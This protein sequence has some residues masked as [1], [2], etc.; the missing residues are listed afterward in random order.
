MAS[1]NNWTLDS[2]TIR[3]F[4]GVAG[5]QIYRFDGKPGLL[6]GNNGVGKSTAAQC[7][8]WTLYGKF[9]AEVLQNTAFNSFM[10]PVGTSGAKWYGQAT[11]SNG[12]G[13]MIVTR[14][15]TP[16]SFSVEV[17]STTCEGDEAVEQLDR[18]LGLDMSGFVRTVLLQQSRIRGLLLDSPKDR[19][20]ALDRLL[21]MDD[22]ENI[23]TRLKPRDFIKTAEVR[24]ENIRIAQQDH[25]SKEALLL[26]QRDEA[27][28]H[29]REYQ[30]RSKDFNIVGLRNAFTR[31]NEQLATLAAKYEVDLATLPECANVD[32]AE[33]ISEQVVAALSRIRS[34]SNLQRKLTEVDGKISNYRALKSNFEKEH[35]KLTDLCDQRDAWLK[36]KGKPEDIEAR[37]KRLEQDLVAART[38]LKA[39]GELRQLLADARQYLEHSPSDNCPVCEQSIASPAS[40]IADLSARLENTTTDETAAL[41]NRLEELQREI[42]SINSALEN[43]G[44][45]QESLKKAQSA[46]DEVR[47]QVVDALGGTGIPESKVVTR[48]DET[49]LASSKGRDELARGASAIE[50]HLSKVEAEDRRINS[51]L[52]PVIRRR[53]DLAK[54]ED[55]WKQAQDSHTADEEAAAELELVAD[56]FAELRE[57]LLG[58]KNEIATETLAI[59][60]PRAEGLYQTLVRHPVFDRLQITTAPKANKIDY[61]FEVSIDGDAKSARE[62]RLVLSDGQVTATAIGLFFALSDAD[63]HNLDLLYVDDPTQNL[64]SPC[65]E[66]MAKVIADIGKERQVIIST[67]DEDFV[68]FLEA[69]GFFDSAVVHHLERWDGNPVVSTRVAQ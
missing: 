67:Q 47:G 48:L 59:A 32:E 23:L 25:E 31:I 18:L 19:N 54:L 63:T 65:K 17:D 13:K 3:N 56:Q 4:R 50:E 52:I 44:E 6:H 36:A 39:A 9:P 2:L 64:D 45:V 7:L 29:A 49:I 34:D 55:D 11:F 1:E 58:A 5:E 68:S 14:S 27:Q 66:A 15:Q 26:K 42:D 41:E 53:A 35:G 43:L 12:S 28:Q 37:R 57:A 60:S 30:F 22:I 40:L 21:G 33:S 69:E 20:A 61:S 51:G 38:M 46:V 24:R 10:V 8:Q 62:A 16:K